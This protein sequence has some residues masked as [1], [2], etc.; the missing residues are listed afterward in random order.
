MI[1]CMYEYR[2]EHDTLV[3][4]DRCYMCNE[5]IYEGDE[6]YSIEAK[7]FCEEC[8]DEFKIILEKYEEEI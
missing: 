6:Y 3:E 1:D 7:A 4:V 5:G 8:A 2:Y